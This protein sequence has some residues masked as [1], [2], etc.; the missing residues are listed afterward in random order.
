VVHPG[1]EI[2]EIG[3]RPARPHLDDLLRRRHPD[4]LERLVAAGAL[5]EIE[6]DRSRALAAVAGMVDYA[7]R[8]EKKGRA[9]RSPR[10]ANGRPARISTT[11]CAADIPTPLSAASP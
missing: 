3:E 7:Q 5:D 11:S 8:R 6:P 1:R 2:P 9:A 10:S 4:T